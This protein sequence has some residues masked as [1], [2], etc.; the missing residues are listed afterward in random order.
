[1]KFMGGYPPFFSLKII[2]TNRKK[3]S[4]GLNQ[5]TERQ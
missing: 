3:V 5:T 4:T 2:G 1:M